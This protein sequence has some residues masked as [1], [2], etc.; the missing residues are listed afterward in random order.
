MNYQESNLTSF[1]NSLCQLSAHLKEHKNQAAAKPAQL[2]ASVSLSAAIHNN[3]LHELSLRLEEYRNQTAAEL[4]QIQTS[5]STIQF[6]LEKQNV[7][8]SKH[9]IQTE[10]D[11]EQLL[12]T[13]IIVEGH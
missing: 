1:N 11:F 8:L 4:A 3:S 6:V 9:Q 2:Q 12:T 13:H 5:L 7:R 10:D